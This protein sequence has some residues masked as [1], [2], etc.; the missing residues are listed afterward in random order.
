[1]ST[2]LQCSCLTAPERLRRG[3]T[4]VELLVVI[5]IIGIL[6]GLLLPA[7]NAAREA[8]RRTQCQ[9][10]LRN[11]AQ[12]ILQ[13]ESAKGYL[14][15][16]GWG[17]AWTGDADRGSGLKQPGSW[18]YCILPYIDQVPASQI[19]AGLADN[20]G[21]QTSPKAKATLAL[22]QTPLALFHCPSRRRLQLYPDA[23]SGQ[24]NCP[25]AT[26]VAHIDYAGNGGDDKQVDATQTFQPNSF[27]QGDDPKFWTSLTLDTGV[28]LQHCQL[29]MALIADGAS[30]TYLIGEKYLTPDHY[31]DG[32]D[33][34]DNENAYSGVNWDTT[35]TSGFSGAGFGDT[36]HGGY[37]IPLQDTPG[38]SSVPGTTSF[39]TFGSAHPGTF[40]MVFC[41]GSVHSISYSIDPETHRRLSN[42]AD[43]Q[44]VDGSKF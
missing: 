7:V 32:E 13:H 34:G 23:G 37:Q 16:A 11:L 43:G 33:L 19:G 36:S 17:Y 2:M 44:P 26:S 35:R 5:T 6:M 21:S 25:A 41:D 24:I 27:S 30:N 8:G 3:F 14:P 15:T 31:A 12:A 4:L 20:N 29:K 42:R 1:M 38:N 9:N 18:A 40:S 39:W 10:N 28:I 22:V